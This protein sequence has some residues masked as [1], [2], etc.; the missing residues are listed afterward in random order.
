MPLLM[1]SATIVWLASHTIDRHLSCPRR[2]VRIV[3]H[4]RKTIIGDSI[5]LALFASVFVFLCFSRDVL[6]S[7]GSCEP[8]NCPL[9]RAAMD[10]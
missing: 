1:A 3:P 9:V 2:F 8:F 4:R 10:N 7:Q 5:R 6:T